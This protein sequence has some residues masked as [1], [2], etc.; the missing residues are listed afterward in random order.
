[1]CAECRMSPCHPRCPNALGDR[2]VYRCIMCCEGI[3]D[4]EIY[5]D[6]PDGPIC[7]DCFC[8]MDGKDVLDLCG[9]GESLKTAEEEDL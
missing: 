6:S 2:S 4:G 7:E 1:M 3:F 9:F 5:W 8:D